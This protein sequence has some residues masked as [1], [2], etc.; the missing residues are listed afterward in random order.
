MTDHHKSS[1]TMT[2]VAQGLGKAAA[3]DFSTTEV[4]VEGE[5]YSN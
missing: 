3:D 4:D 5:D 2:N 1:L